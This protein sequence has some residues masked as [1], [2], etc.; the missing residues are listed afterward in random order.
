[1]WNVP[2]GE[3]L[4]A[5]EVVLSLASSPRGLDVL[6]A[7]HHILH[8][9]SGLEP[10]GMHRVGCQRPRR[11]NQRPTSAEIDQR[12]L[13]QARNRAAQAPDDLEPWLA[14]PV[15][16]CTTNS[17]RRRAARPEFLPAKDL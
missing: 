9:G 7:Y 6:D 3:E 17:R 13:F 11:F 2:W 15:T 1:M 12:Q 5:D 14:S 16:H 8:R 10:D 4:Q